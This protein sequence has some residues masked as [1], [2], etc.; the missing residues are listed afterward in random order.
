M[1]FT[2]ISICQTQGVA[3]VPPPELFWVETDQ[4]YCW[5]GVRGLMV[6][7][8]RETGLK[9]YR[10]LRHS[11]DSCPLTGEDMFLAR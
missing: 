3:K 4:N 6:A 7:G 2:A 11:M 9:I 8:W 1:T 5:G 10:R